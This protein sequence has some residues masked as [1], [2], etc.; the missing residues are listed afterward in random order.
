MSKTTEVTQKP[1]EAHGVFYERLCKVF[2]TYNPFNTEAP[3]NMRIVNAAFV[4]QSAP[5]ICWKMQ[6]LEGFVGIN[7]SQLLEIA[8]KIYANWDLQ[9]QREADRRIRQKAT[10]LAAALSHPKL[11]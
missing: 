4:A 9:A 11:A 7:A 5:D 2:W 3:E 6:K 8:H 1:D 10:L